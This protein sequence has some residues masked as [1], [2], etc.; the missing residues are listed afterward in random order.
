MTLSLSDL[1]L[2]ELEGSKKCT[3]FGPHWHIYHD[4][5]DMGTALRI[6]LGRSA[7][8]LKQP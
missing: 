6:S 4:H 1:F 7:R 3:A 8:Q 5:P 2:I